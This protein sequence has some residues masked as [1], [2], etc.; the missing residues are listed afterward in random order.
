MSDH[1]LG[2]DALPVTASEHQ[3]VYFDAVRALSAQLVLVGH[4]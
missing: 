2:R 3:I 4:A 1:A